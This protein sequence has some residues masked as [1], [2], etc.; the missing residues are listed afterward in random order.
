MC[1]RGRIPVGSDISFNAINSTIAAIKIKILVKLNVAERIQVFL[2]NRV[3]VITHIDS[4]ILSK[5]I[6]CYAACL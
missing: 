4:S 1:S 3:R 2:K 6:L 5:L